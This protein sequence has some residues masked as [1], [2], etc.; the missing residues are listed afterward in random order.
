M[1]KYALV[2]GATVLLGCSSENG[3]LRGS[4]EDFY[5]LTFESVRARLYPTE[6]SIEYVRAGGQVP[7][8]VTL[9]QRE[10]EPIKAATYD[11]LTLGN[12]TGRSGDNDIPRMVGGELK[13]TEFQAVNGSRIAGEFEAQFATGEDKA[14]LTGDFD[15]T[16]EV[17]DQIIGYDVD[18]SYLLDAGD[19][20][21]AQ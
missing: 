17:I 8:R 6:L 20:G 14:S 13:L 1:K 21:D 9:V 5:N 11:L 3:G 16:L 7:V 4:L 10:G 2:L 12:I 19:A 18:L 15:T